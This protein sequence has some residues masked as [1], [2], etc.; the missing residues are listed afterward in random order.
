[1]N[2]PDFKENWFV[3]VWIEDNMWKANNKKILKS[4]RNKMMEEISPDSEKLSNEWQG[5]QQMLKGLCEL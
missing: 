1:M 5:N 2:A 4:K 3:W